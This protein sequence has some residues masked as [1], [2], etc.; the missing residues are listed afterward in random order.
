M[1]ALFPLYTLQALIPYFVV[2]QFI[3]GALGVAMGPM[4]RAWVSDES[5]AK[6][7]GL[8]TSL[9]WVSLTLGQI[10]GPVLGTFIAQVWSFEYSFYASALLSF[11]TVLLI[12]ISFP[13]RRGISGGAGSQTIVGGLKSVLRDRLTRFLFLSA[14]FA[15]MGVASMRSF[16]PLYASGQIR[17][18]T[19]EI[20]ILISATS[21]AQLIAMALLGLV[22]DRFGRKRMVL[23]GFG[24]SSLAFLFFFIARSSYELTL[25]ALVVSVGL[26][27]S[28]FLLLSLIPE[29]APAR[30]YGTVV[31]VYGSFEDAGFILGP[32][33][34][35]FIWAAYSPVSIFAA[36]SLTQILGGLFLLPLIRKR[37][38]RK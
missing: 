14:L 21:A 26:S 28:S 17:M 13:K 3:S 18:S 11:L 1:T 30:L 23:L 34:F 31:G 37:C 9:W 38:R 20:G 35:G 7:V 32:A 22:S 5:P 19:L 29:V 12:P 25:V 2:L 4:T 16:L 33:A 6:S 15:F 24:L 36:A 27:A 8:F 10:I